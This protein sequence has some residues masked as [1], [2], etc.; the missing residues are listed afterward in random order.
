MARIS[1]GSKFA[2][3]IQLKCREAAVK[4]MTVNFPLRAATKRDTLSL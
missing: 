4:D 2:S 1:L 3:L